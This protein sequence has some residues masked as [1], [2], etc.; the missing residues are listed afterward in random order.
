M[1]GDADVA[2]EAQG[3]VEEGKPAVGAHHDAGGVVRVEDQVARAA[4]VVVVGG[5]AE[6]AGVGVQ[7]GGAADQGERGRVFDV[8]V[9]AGAHEGVLN[10]CVSGQDAYVGAADISVGVAE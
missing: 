7:V 4:A 5:I 2:S 1:P 10:V 3:F 9:G 6:A 8:A